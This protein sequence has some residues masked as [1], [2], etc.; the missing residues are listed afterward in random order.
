MNKTGMNDIAEDI[1]VSRNT[2]SK[3]MNGRGS[4]SEK[5]RHQVI[6]AAIRLNYEKLPM[7]LLEKFEETNNIKEVINTKNILVIATAPDFSSFWG[8]MINGITK[9]LVEE[10]Y[11]CFYNFITFE[12]EEHFEIPDI[13]DACQ[14][15]GIIVMNVYN[16][17][18]VKKIA[19]TN[20]PTV[21]FDMPL[22][23][24]VEDIK[25]DIVVTEGRRSV[26]QITKKLLEANH[27]RLGFVGDITYCKSVEERWRGFV[28]AHNALGIKIHTE[29]CYVGEKAGHYYFDKEIEEIMKAF[30]KEGHKLPQA[31]VCANDEIAYKL[32]NELKKY[33][34]QVPKDIKV[35]GF[36]DILNEGNNLDF[37][38]T[39]NIATESIGKRLAEKIVWR[40][41]N[42]T[43]DYE[44][45]KIYG[46]VKFRQSTEG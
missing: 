20:I 2:V 28:R 34:Y 21:Y 42:S 37:L 32:I 33:G 17:K 18:A 15:A 24:E 26:Y 27:K 13:L 31:F 6:E 8:K 41:K 12:Q 23:M 16:K 30:I 22:G 46:M 7:H 1:G 39:V 4:V 25:G 44:E 35:S 3:V 19:S 40:I 43:R 36:D 10:E 5:I 45:I 29:Y 14:I 38:T 11:N 9:E